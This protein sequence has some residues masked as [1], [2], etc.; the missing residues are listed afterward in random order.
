VWLS[1]FQKPI[2]HLNHPTEQ[3]AHRHYCGL[4]QHWLN[5]SNNAEARQTLN[6]G[7]S[8]YINVK[9][10]KLSTTINKILLRYSMSCTILTPRKT[11]DGMEKHGHTE[12]AQH[13]HCIL[14]Y[15]LKRNACK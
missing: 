2:Y 1:Q 14:A 10:G 6:A 12:T 11:P 15:P 8:G 5:I 4:Y 3:S 7:K 9:S 13:L